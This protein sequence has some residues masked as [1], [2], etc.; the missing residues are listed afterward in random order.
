MSAPIR[1]LALGEAGL[2]L[3]G[4][5]W[6]WLRSVPISYRFDLD[7][8]AQGLLWAGLFSLG[9]LGLYRL[10]KSWGRP[11]KVHEFLEREVFPLFHHIGLGE[12]AL[13]LVLVGWGEELLFR[14]VL[15]REIGLWGASVIFGIVHG[16]SRAL[17]PLTVWATLMGAALGVIYHMTENLFIAALAHAL[18]DGVAVMYIKNQAP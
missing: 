3:L 17:W 2:I 9:N 16:P 13:L 18:Y 1:F 14:G 7:A 10:S 12:V 15:Q 11:A 6:A 8:L 4:L 5:V